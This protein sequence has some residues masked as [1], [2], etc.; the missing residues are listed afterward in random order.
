VHPFDLET[1]RSR[2]IYLWCT[3]YS[4]LEDEALL[5]EYRSFLS[6]S[7]RQQEQR[8]HFARD[9]RRY[10]VTRA[11]TLKIRACAPLVSTSPTGSSRP[12]K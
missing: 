2:P 11:L 10:L 12:R 1:G 7:E 4:D 8:F 6:E 5:R 3:F 9:R